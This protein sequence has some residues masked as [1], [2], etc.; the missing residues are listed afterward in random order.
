M[1]KD[2]F[3]EGFGKPE[4]F[5][6]PKVPRVDSYKDTEVIL[7]SAYL[8]KC[9]LNQDLEYGD[10]YVPKSSIKDQE[11]EPR[12][13]NEKID[14]AIAENFDIIQQ[15]NYIRLVSLQ[16]AINILTSLNFIPIDPAVDDG[17]G[18]ELTLWNND[19]EFGLNVEG[20]TL[21]GTYLKAVIL[22]YST[23]EKIEKI[24]SEF[25]NDK[26]IFDLMNEE[27][28]TEDEDEDEE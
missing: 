4:K 17:E 28:S 15:R 19:F 10:W 1:A 16:E 26:T 18:V 20:K 27:E 23:V 25:R 22:A 11:L 5:G 3:G 13:Y 6:F 7:F 12:I 14:D 8:R 9:G 2:N 24:S 21:H